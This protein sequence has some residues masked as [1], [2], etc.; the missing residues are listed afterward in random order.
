MKFIKNITS[1]ILLVLFLLLLILLDI[2]RQIVRFGQ[3]YL[4][5][6]KQDTMQQ[7]SISTTG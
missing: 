6:G 3:E 5:Y 1:T 7:T 2:D 4:R